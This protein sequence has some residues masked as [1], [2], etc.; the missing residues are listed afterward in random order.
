MLWAIPPNIT[1]GGYFGIDDDD[2]LSDDGDAGGD[3]G[4]GW[5]RRARLPAMYRISSRM[6]VGDD[7]NDDLNG[8]CDTV[9]PSLEQYSLSS[10]ISRSPLRF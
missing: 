4:G 6:D 1:N 5:M 2:D 9:N 8:A 10:L 7:D 3:S